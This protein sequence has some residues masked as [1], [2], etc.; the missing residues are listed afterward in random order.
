M[1][2]DSR[3]PGFSLLVKPASADCN[4]RCD[5]CFYLEKKALYALEPTHRM[6]DAVLEKLI[7]GYLS[8]PQQL[9]TFAWQ[10]GEPALM[11]LNFFKRAAELQM[12]HARRGAPI[13]NSLQ[14]NGTL[15]SD[16]L[17]EYLSR[18][19][20][21]LGVS[22]DG[23]PELHDLYRKFPSG[24]PSHATVMKGVQTLRRHKVQFNILILVSQANVRHARTVYRYLVHQGFYHHQYIP[25][26]EFDPGGGLRPYSITGEEWGRFLCELFDCWHPR[27]VHRVSIRHFD[28]I[29]NKGLYGLD[30]ICHLSKNCCQ[31]FVVEYNGDIYPCD[32]FV[33]KDLKIGNISDT[34]WGEAFSSATYQAFGREKAR[35][36]PA[37]LECDHLDLCAGDCPKHRVRSSS[38][39]PVASHLCSG[40]TTFLNYT[41]ERIE[42][43]ENRIRFFGAMGLGAGGENRDRQTKPQAAPN[44]SC[45]CGS[46]KKYKKCCGVK[47]RLFGA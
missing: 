25:C 18:Q 12:R 28:A 15:I 43:L 42:A 20:F 6:N 29:L 46:G 40:W 9:Y 8:T 22:L 34:T 17:A 41:A 14:T 5:Y 35:L 32:F 45:S 16:A 23:P 24:K 30:T 11:G 31:Y 2:F 10:G 26:V 37:C 39:G 13:V 7:R 27:D 38:Q 19:G 21:L 3:T 47:T 36:S 4:L 44:Q 33:R 1:V